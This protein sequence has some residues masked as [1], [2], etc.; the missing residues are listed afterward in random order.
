MKRKMACFPVQTPTLAT[1]SKTFL[2]LFVLYSFFTSTK[3]SPFLY[4]R[5]NWT[6][7]NGSREKKF[8]YFFFDT[9]DKTIFQLQTKIL[10]WRNY[11]EQKETQNSCSIIHFSDFWAWT[12]VILFFYV[13]CVLLMPKNRVL[14]PEIHP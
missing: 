9:L 11:R 14:C 6:K 8:C 2:K 12:I 3:D 1:S 4:P 7:K 10:I 5:V 13:V